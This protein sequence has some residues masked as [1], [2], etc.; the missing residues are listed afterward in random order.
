MSLGIG[1]DT[2]GTYTDAVI[3]DFEKQEVVAKTKALTTKEDLARGIGMALDAL[4]IKLLSQA[5]VIALSTTLAT[6][7]CVENKGGRAKLVL[8][9]TSKKVLDWINAETVYGLKNEDIMCIETNGSFNGE[10]IEQPDW[11]KL[12]AEEDAWFS[13]AEAL[14]VAEVNALRN[15]AICEKNAKEKLSAHYNIPIVMATEIAKNLNV[16]ERGATSLLN[17]RLLPVIEEFMEAVSFALK[18]RKLDIPTMV[19]RSDGSLMTDK[20]SYSRPVETILSGPASSVL[21]GRELTN[22]ENCLIIDMGGTTTDISIVKKNIPAMSDGIRIGGWR[23][24]IKGVYI[25]TF[26]LGGDSRI[27]YRDNKLE[28]S[29][30]RVQPLCITAVKYPEIIIQLQNLLQ[31]KDFGANP[32]HEFLCLVRPPKDISQYS[33]YEINLLE[34][35]EN[36]PIMLGDD[37]LDL[38]SLKSERLE[39]EGIIM[40]CGLTPTDIMHIKGDFSMHNKEASILA[41]RYRLKALNKYEDTSEGLAAFCDEVYD[42]VAKKLYENIVRIIIANS[43]P[44]NFADGFE[45]DGKLDFLI[46]QSWLERNSPKKDKFF[47][48][49][50]STNATLVGVGAPIHIFLPIVA[51]ALGTDYIIPQHAGVANAVGAIVADISVQ[52]DIKIAP[53]YTANGTS[54]YTVFTNDGNGIFKTL[55]EAIENAQRAAISAATIE[56][57]KRGA[58][59]ELAVKL[60]VNT[61]TA[62]AKG[63]SAIDLGTM[64]TAIVSGRVNA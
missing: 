34:K 4:P 23:T 49:G 54:E 50:F 39:N 28:L 56:A 46:S 10:F 43:Y 5:T 59:G 30:R 18:S 33:Y 29:T 57:K 51:K 13:D 37:S 60:E 8:M 19:V 58:L 64:A 16:M 21:G 27:I 25:D 12:L 17:A 42:M 24:Q 15:G 31:Q 7:A 20:I 2:G 53:H 47:D 35:L 6:N 14:S 1:V 9:G 32:L 62:F 63:G 61:N 36:G 44:K 26:G 55:E 45:S 52:S 22:C 38:Y 11:D 48:F 41:A 40:R 3:Y